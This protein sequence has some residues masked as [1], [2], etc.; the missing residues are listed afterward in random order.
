MKNITDNDKQ[1]VIWCFDD[2]VNKFGNIIKQR[3]QTSNR[4]GRA[5]HDNTSTNNKFVTKKSEYVQNNKEKFESR[6][7]EWKVINS[8]LHNHL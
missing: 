3:Q 6:V 4:Y 5:I 8:Y 1:I 2:G 7:G